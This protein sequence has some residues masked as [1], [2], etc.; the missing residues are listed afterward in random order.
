MNAFAVLEP[1]PPG[2]APA[3]HD[4]AS[5]DRPEIAWG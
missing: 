3:L 4:V 1:P 5:Q 2:P